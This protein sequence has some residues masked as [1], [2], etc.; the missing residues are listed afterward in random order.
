MS[1]SRATRPLM[2]YSLCPERYSLRLTM[3][4]PGFVAST[5]FSSPFFFL[6][7]NFLSLPPVSSELSVPGSALAASWFNCAASAVSVAVAV[8]VAESPSVAF[9]SAFTKRLKAFDFHFSQLKQGVPLT[10]RIARFVVRCD[11]LVSCSPVEY[12]KKYAIRDGFVC[13]EGR[14]FRASGQ[15]HTRGPPAEPVRYEPTRKRLAG[16]CSEPSRLAQGWRYGKNVNTMF[17]SCL[18]LR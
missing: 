16:S 12:G 5:G 7:N 2:R 8:A 14:D 4:S 6:L 1:R 13:L 15:S 3:I 9:F 18:A 11:P 10:P 17:L